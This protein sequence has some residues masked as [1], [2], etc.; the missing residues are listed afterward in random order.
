MTENLVR[1]KDTSGRAGSTCK[2]YVLPGQEFC[3]I[4]SP[5]PFPLTMTP[6][7]VRSLICDELRKLGQRH[8]AGMEKTKLRIELLKL[9]RDLPAAVPPSKENDDDD[10]E[11]K[12]KR[13]TDRAHAK[14]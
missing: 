6:D 9:L 7:S 8:S 14:T 10:W 13:M 2:R 1:C 5:D 3:A 4:H 12:L 11:K